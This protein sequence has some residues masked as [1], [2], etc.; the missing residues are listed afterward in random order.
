MVYIHD[1]STKKISQERISEREGGYAYGE[2]PPPTTPRMSMLGILCV[3]QAVQR[4]PEYICSQNPWRES[5]GETNKRKEILS[6]W[7]LLKV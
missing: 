1:C 2:T 6:C 3:K 4:I 5:F 7:N